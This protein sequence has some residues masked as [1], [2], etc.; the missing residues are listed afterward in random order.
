[1]R[2]STLACVGV[3]AAAAAS[4]LCGSDLGSP[5][6]LGVNCPCGNDDPNAGCANSSGRG[7]RLEALGSTSVSAADL[8]F[9][10]TQLPTSSLS[11]LVLSPNQRRVPFGDGLLCV[12]P[13]MAR[14]R[15][16]L[17]S[18]QAGTVTYTDVLPILAAHGV[19]AQAGETWN[20][21]VWFRDPA[22]KGVC[23]GKSNL[24]HAWTLT[25]TP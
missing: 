16:H 9:R 23:D 17:N 1:M 11:L 12:G 8:Q 19:V 24:T 15:T 13:G 4:P 21:Q 6:C 25:F 10:A 20:A 22:H 3:L 5:Y 18:G 14:L 7:A 2:L